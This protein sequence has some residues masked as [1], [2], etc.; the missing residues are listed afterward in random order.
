ML[1]DYERHLLLSCL[2]NAI[3]TIDLNGRE[4]RCLSEWAI[5]MADYDVT[6]EFALREFG[7]RLGAPW[8][9]PADTPR[10]MSRPPVQV[11][12]ARILRIVERKDEARSASQTS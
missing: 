3:G 2:A 7:K 8:Q 9:K 4:A 1:S 10:L 6:I 12:A 11:R 5:E